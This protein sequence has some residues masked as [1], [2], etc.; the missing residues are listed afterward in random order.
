MGE[1]FYK[2]YYSKLGGAN[3]ADELMKMLLKGSGLK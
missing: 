3:S 2:I 1:G